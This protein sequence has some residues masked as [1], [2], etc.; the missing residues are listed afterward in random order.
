MSVVWDRHPDAVLALAGEGPRRADIARHAARL[1]GRVALLGYRTD[2][3]DLLAAADLFALPSLQ[4]GLG[5]A[6]LEAVLAQVPAVGTSVG[7]IPDLIGPGDGG[8]AG[9][10][11]PAGDPTALGA[12]LAEALDD[13]AEARRRA[14]RAATRAGDRFAPARLVNETLRAWGIEPSVTA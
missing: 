8:P 11:V 3:P 2:I 7:A 4:E 12:A 5:S 9:W 6:L 1:G 10:V 14:R 13:P